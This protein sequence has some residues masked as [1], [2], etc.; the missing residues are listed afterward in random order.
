[1]KSQMSTKQTKAQKNKKTAKTTAGEHLCYIPISGY[2]RLSVT[3]IFF[4]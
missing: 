4:K 3:L 1:M 2:F